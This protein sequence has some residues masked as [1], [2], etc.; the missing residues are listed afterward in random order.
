MEHGNH[1]TNLSFVSKWNS[2]RSAR[3]ICVMQ[4]K[5][6]GNHTMKGLN[7]NLPWCLEHENASS[8]AFHDSTFKLPAFCFSLHFPIFKIV[9]L[10]SQSMHHNLACCSKGTLSSDS[11]SS[12]SWC[13]T[14]HL[15]EDT[16]KQWARDRN[17]HVNFLKYS[18]NTWTIFLAGNLAWIL[19]LKKASLESFWNS[20]A[21]LVVLC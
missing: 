1:P 17:L 8:S 5:I 7:G 13:N 20:L 10:L 21:S 3:R 2:R 9:S 15:C 12:K 18:G 11:E 14:G 16:A 6:L 19:N 4:P